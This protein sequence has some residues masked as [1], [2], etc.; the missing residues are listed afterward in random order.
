[1]S[2]QDEAQTASVADLPRERL[3]FAHALEDLAI[4]A[5]RGEGGPRVEAKVDALDLGLTRVG[6]V[7]ERVERILEVDPR[8]GVP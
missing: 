3:G 1:M 5:E 4:L 7:R 2:R 8:F 6:Q